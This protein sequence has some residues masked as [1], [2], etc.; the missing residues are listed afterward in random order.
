MEEGE[1]SHVGR[2]RRRE[3]MCL[4]NYVCM[5]GKGCPSIYMGEGEVKPPLEAPPPGRAFP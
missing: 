1:L 4:K 2:G 3:E 5:R